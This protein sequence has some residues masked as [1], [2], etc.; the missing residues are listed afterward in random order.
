[1]RRATL[2]GLAGVPLFIVGSLLE[3]NTSDHASVW[4]L[5]RVTDIS[6]L[7]CAVLAA[8]LLVLD[9]ARPRTTLAVGAAVLSTLA[10]GQF[11][12]YPVE[13]G[14]SNAAVGMYVQLAGALALLAGSAWRLALAPDVPARPSPIGA[15][16]VVAG[17]ALTLG[18]SFMDYFGLDRDYVSLWGAVQHMDSGLAVYLGALAAIVVAD[19]VR[20]HR[21]LAVA[22]LV[23]AGLVLGE[24]VFFPLELKF[25]L[26]GIGAYLL[27]VGALTAVAGSAIRVLAGGATAR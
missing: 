3:N 18:A 7:I 10:A 17:G 8:A 4:K 26:I 1:M 5:S 21:V 24:A 16:I 23:V 11:A 6:M 27:V 9:G 20:P 22:A 2:V 12:W 15:A 13:G 14:L 25:K 19:V